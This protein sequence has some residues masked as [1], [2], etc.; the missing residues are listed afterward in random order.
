VKIQDKDSVTLVNYA[1]K[2]VKRH[3]SKAGYILNLFLEELVSCVISGESLMDRVS[4][5]DGL[6]IMARKKSPPLLGIE[7]WPSNCRSPFR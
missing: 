4:S 6:D 1:M 3:G 7:L 5:R 2:A